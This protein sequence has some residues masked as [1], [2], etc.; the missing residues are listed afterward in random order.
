MTLQIVI[1]P[2]KKNSCLLAFG[3]F[4]LVGSSS[5][6]QDASKF[7]IQDSVHPAGLS[8]GELAPDFKAED[9]NGNMHQLSE[10]LKEG[11]VVLIFYRGA[12]CPYCINYLSNITDSLEQIEMAGASVLAITPQGVAG[13]SKASEKLMNG[14]TL[15]SDTAGEIMAAYDTKFF[16]TDKYSNKIKFSKGLNLAKSNNQTTAQLP[17]P[18]TY[19]VGRD[20]TII[21]RHFDYDYSKRYSI[22]AILNTLEAAE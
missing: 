4:V 10:A 6:A 11:P 8:V 17:V 3:L 7:G 14:I 19:V 13:V 18:A 9:Q 20:G 16:V 5:K 22:Q 21:D 2:M 15:L 12:W 1:C